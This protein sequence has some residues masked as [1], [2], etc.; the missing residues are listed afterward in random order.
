MAPLG[1]VNNLTQEVAI[2]LHVT[3]LRQ[4]LTSPRGS[5]SRTPSSNLADDEDEDRH[6]PHLRPSPAVK[7][8][9]LLVSSGRWRIP[10]GSGRSSRQASEHPPFQAQGT[11]MPPP[12]PA[13]PEM[14]RACRVVSSDAIINVARRGSQC[15]THNEIAV[16]SARGRLGT[17]KDSLI[18]Q[19]RARKSSGSH[20]SPE[21]E[22]SLEI[23]EPE[24]TPLGKVAFQD[25]VIFEPSTSTKANIKSAQPQLKDKS[26]FAFMSHRAMSAVEHQVARE[27]RFEA[28]QED[29][30]VI[31]DDQDDADIEDEDRLSEDED[32]PG[33][34]PRAARRDEGTSHH[35][36]ASRHKSHPKTPKRPLTRQRSEYMP[37]R[38][39]PKRQK[40][41]E[42]SDMA[43]FAL[44]TPRART[45]TWSKVLRSSKNAANRQPKR[46]LQDGA[47]PMDGHDSQ[48]KCAVG[49]EENQALAKQHSDDIPNRP[50]RYQQRVRQSAQVYEVLRHVELPELLEEAPS[51]GQAPVKPDH[52]HENVLPERQ[53]PD[54]CLSRPDLA[55][56]ADPCEVENEQDIDSMTPW[57]LF[58]AD[59]V[60]AIEDVHQAKF[61]QQTARPGTNGRPCVAPL[62]QRTKVH[63]VKDKEDVVD[64]TSKTQGPVMGHS[65]SMPPCDC[66]GTV[67]PSQHEFD[68]FSWSSDEY[69]GWDGDGGVHGQWS[70]PTTLS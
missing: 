14:A 20:D 50:V 8:R 13:K 64:N 65:E 16:S 22:D 5:V 61:A 39:R 9:A 43:S 33:L 25:E 7:K 29:T 49:V 45:K 51:C 1:G 54:P 21:Q 23:D 27:L 47:S 3:D 31:E 44:R 10:T 48:D 56:P 28:D 32:S 58:D 15:S 38:Q 62:L 53:T 40:I 35:V 18:S 30:I 63:Q 46:A 11:M 26:S 4:T 34:L 52:M 57:L 2:P 24:S 70:R 36:P 69:G 55:Q 17:A 59:M 19:I 68:H 67:Q 60:E 66:N 42:D 12:D 6:R 37:A 41:C